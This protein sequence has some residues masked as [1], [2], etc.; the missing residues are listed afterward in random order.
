[1]N[2]SGEVMAVFMGL[3]GFLGELLL[4]EKWRLFWGLW[5]REVS[6]WWWFEWKLLKTGLKMDCLMGCL[7]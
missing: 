7:D 5:M 3:C 2:K 4:M 1:V 6:I